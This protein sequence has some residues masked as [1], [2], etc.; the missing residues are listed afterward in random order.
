MERKKKK[1]FCITA[2]V[3]KLLNSSYKVHP[4]VQIQASPLSN[5]STSLPY[6]LFAYLRAD[7]TALTTGGGEEKAEIW[8][9]VLVTWLLQHLSTVIQLLTHNSAFMTFKP[10]QRSLS[11]SGAWAFLVFR[12]HLKSCLSKQASWITKHT[13]WQF[14]TLKIALYQENH[15]WRLWLIKSFLRRKLQSSLLGGNAW[16]GGFNP[17]AS[18]ELWACWSEQDWTLQS[19]TLSPNCGCMIFTSAAMWLPRWISLDRVVFACLF[20]CFS[21]FLSTYF[22]MTRTARSAAGYVNVQKDITI[23]YHFADIGLWRVFLQLELHSKV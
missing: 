1:E 12:D 14:I 5:S 2:T 7:S 23:F 16:S 15:I 17:T 10:V 20:V 6:R 3:E 9:H 4:C 18:G 8:G 19:E 11:S 22:T 21:F 13:F